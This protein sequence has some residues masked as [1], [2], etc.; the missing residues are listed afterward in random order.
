MSM[1]RALYDALTVGLG[2]ALGAVARYGTS[3]A[4]APWGEYA[5]LLVINI[6]GCLVMGAAKPGP[7]WGTGFLGGFTTFSAFAVV[8]ATS[9]AAVAAGFTAAMTVGCIAAWCLGDAWHRRNS[10]RR[11]ARSGA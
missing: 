9:H 3:A 4:L 7:F 5:P 11:Q 10:G 2:V 6:V 8:T 1:P